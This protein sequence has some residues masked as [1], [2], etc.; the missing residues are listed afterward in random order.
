MGVVSGS[1]SNV[2]QVAVPLPVPG[3]FDY[4]HEG[5]PLPVGC[6]VRV[7]FGHRE[8]IGFVVGHAAA[9]DP[10]RPLKPLTAVLDRQSWFTPDLWSLLRFASDYYQ[11]ELGEVMATALP[12]ALRRTRLPKARPPLR[13]SLSRTGIDLARTPLQAQL[14]QLLAGGDQTETKLAE[15]LPGAAQALRQL[16][17]RGVLAAVPEPAGQG[18]QGLPGPELGEEQAQALA[19]LLQLQGFAPALLEGVT[20]SGKTE[21]YLRLAAAVLAAGRQVLILVPEIGLVPQMLARACERLHGRLAVLHS[22]LAETER[23]LIHQSVANGEVDVVIG[24]RSALFAPLSRLGLIVIDEEHDA[25]YKQ[26]EGLRYHARDLALVRGQTLDIPVLLGS[27]TPSLET[28]LNV[29]RGRC[30]QLKLQQRAGAALPPQ[31]WLEDLSTAP[32]R[33]VLGREALRLIGEELAQQ[34]QVLVFRNRRGYSPVLL[35][36]D[37][38]WQAQC[39][40]CDARLVLHRREGRLRC[41]HCGHQE[42]LPP[43]CPQCGSLGLRPLGSGTERVEDVL[44]RAF[45]GTPLFR[46][47]RDSVARKGA[48]EASLDSLRRGGAALLVG[49]QMLAKGHDLPRLGLVVICQLDEA[50]H[51]VDYRASER[52]AQL[53]VQVAGRAGRR[54]QR[55]RVV[56]ETAWPAHPVL[57][58]LLSEGY[59]A[60]AA[61]ALQQRV[62]AGLPP[63]THAAL[64][65]A[66]DRRREPLEQL[67]AELREFLLAQ[68]EA[69]V[70]V[71]GPILPPMARRA[72]RERGQLLL[73][74]PL[75]PSLQRA[76]RLLRAELA[77]R[78]SPVHCSIDVDPLDWY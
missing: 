58:T 5:S 48:R 62:A 61:Q 10:Q 66:D 19:S 8:C 1:D 69:G 65:R 53:L 39:P 22:E 6:R 70:Q 38:G 57:Q 14:L 52:L 45:P 71:H 63:A 47:D 31:W 7:S 23:L 74:S 9:A 46:F 15:R 3:P 44:A 34:R 75:R 77:R 68:V 18:G 54:E 51:S 4:S 56:L 78:R 16:Q 43:S 55:G 25:A 35:C 30:R 50:L 60:F 20:G 36:A 32:T 41:H 17:R 33:E 11:R 64:L 72:G 27:A 28:L 37:C 67:L 12:T 21:V 59:P 73:L 49:T 29:Q 13:W 24:T 26:Q 2:V 40:D 42:V 76:L